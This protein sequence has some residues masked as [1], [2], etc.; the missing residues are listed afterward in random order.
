MQPYGNASSGVS[1]FELHDRAIDVAF[2][3]GKR[4]R[5]DEIRPGAEHVAAMKRLAITGRG[6]ATYINQHVRSDFAAK[7]RS[8]AD[9]AKPPR[10]DASGPME[11]PQAERIR[12]TTKTAT[13][14]GGTVSEPEDRT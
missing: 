11:P 1:A 7:L 14:R 12:K 9:L 8:R 13:R 2:R 6:L 10:R 4:Y 5:Y 3:D